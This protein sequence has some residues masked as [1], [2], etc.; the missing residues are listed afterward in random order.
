VRGSEAFLS[1][2][3][4][5]LENLE[6][7]RF[8]EEAIE[9]LQRILEVRPDVIA[10]DL[11]PDYFSTKWALGWAQARLIGVQHHHAHIAACLA[12]NHLDGQVIGIALDGTGYGADGAIWGGE[13]LLADY[14]NLERAAHL[15]YVALP[16][17]EAAIREPWRI[18]VSYLVKHYGQSLSAL[19]IPFTKALDRRKLDILL[20]M[21]AR[22][23]NSPLTSSCGRLFDA[24]AALLGLR[25]TVNYEAQA[26][27]ELEMAAHESSDESAYPF[28]L[29]FAGETWCIGTHSL[30][31]W[32]LHDIRRGARAADISR[33][34]HNGLA[35]LFLGIAEK[36]REVHGLNR[37]CLSGGCFQNILL[38]RL[39]LAALRKQKFAVYFQ[40]EV[41]AGDGGISLGQALV[42]AHR[43]RAKDSHS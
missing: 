35:S 39:L 22:G 4:G 10:H 6:S 26:A 30:F 18:A 42:A 15:E 5:D 9:H 21:I 33:R 7:Y 40:S 19:E 34:F 37:V 23:V 3:I 17:G 43:L 29:Q 28:E 16:G 38:F 41:P 32:L 24:V 1:Q 2:H 31:D 13:V 20:Q 12:E 11:H 25:A 14:V 36:L 8:F 27:I